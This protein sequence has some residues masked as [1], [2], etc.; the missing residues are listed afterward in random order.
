MNIHDI[1]GLLNTAGSAAL[2]A[3]NVKRGT[4]SAHPRGFGFVTTEDGTKFFVPPPEMRGVVPGDAVEFRVQAGA[5]PDSE[6]ATVLRI[7]SRPDS[8]W[9]GTLVPFDGH[10]ALRLDA[11]QTCF[12]T[13]ELPDVQFGAPGVVVSVRVPAFQGAP[14]RP[15][16]RVKAKLERVLG[17]REQDGFLQEYALARHDFPV[18]FSDAA[19]AEARAVSQEPVDKTLLSGEREDL[20]AVPIVTIDGESTKDFDD[21]VFAAARDGGWDVLVAIADVS[22]Y[23]RPGG[24]LEREALARATSVYLPGR[25]LPMLPEALSTG[26]C[27]LLPGADR[28]AVVVKMHVQADGVL[29]NVAVNRAVVRS[30]QRLTYSEAQAWSQQD[31]VVNPEVQ[32]SMLALWGLYKVLSASRTE[33]GRLEIETPEPKLL[34]KDDGTFDLAWSDR[35]DAHKLVEELML[36]TNRAVAMRLGEGQGVFRHQPLPEPARWALVREFAQKQGYTLPETPSLSA[37]ADMM[38]VLDGES[39]FKAELHARNSMSPAVYSHDFP[40]HFSL[41][42]SAYTHFTSPIRRFPDLAVHRLLLGE[43]DA[44]VSALARLT[45]HCSERSRAARLC[46][47]M[48]WDSLKKASLWT[49][50]EASPQARAGYVVHQSR[51]GA[52]AVVSDWQ[53]AVFLPAKALQQAGYR[54]DQG[55]DGW[56]TDDE[57]LELGSRLS[58]VLTE[59]VVEDSKTELLAALAPQA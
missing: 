43:T 27:S 34:P 53:T 28:L 2:A 56:C 13:L 10:M 29:A 5:R 1:T 22:H 19:L 3:N 58:L 24:A 46:E 11:D 30:A 39:A 8:V 52:R 17:T 48:V 21:A 6:Q 31:Y 44:T 7:V 25:V 38:Q 32:D 12:P 42:V 47:R 35:T 45:A 26:A 20:R 15:S 9:Q 16:N 59:R 50:Q 57:G 55:R 54:F 33:K 14:R 23:V 49:Q 51:N 37:L 18:M 41:N 36:L 4:V 40:Q